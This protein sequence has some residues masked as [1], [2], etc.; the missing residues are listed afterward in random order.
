MSSGRGPMSGRVVL[1]T[2][3]NSG[4]G[5]VSSRV[6]AE[7]GAHVVMVCRD[8]GRGQEALTEVQRAGSAELMR[9][10]LSSLADVRR[11]ALAFLAR[12]PALHVLLNNAGAYQAER[13][14]T[15]DGLELSFGA[16]HL[17]PY[18]L[19]RLLLDRLRE[20]GGARIVN[21]AS[22]AHRLGRVVLDD[23]QWQRRRYVGFLA[24]AD[25]KLMNILFTRE[26]A[27][28]LRGS[29]VTANSLHPGAIRSGFAVQDTGAFARLTALVG[30]ALLSA[31]EGAAT[32]LHLCCA[33]ELAQVSGEYFSSRRVKAP[34]PQ[35]RDDKAALGLWEASERLAGL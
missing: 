9:C 23:L 13:R 21:V 8:L 24:Y 17:G 20:S 7:R 28:R 12:H 33:P 4:I 32:Q 2:G 22:G 6:L 31:E 27:A 3:A 15:A 14:E 26:L 18:L 35:A 34:W 5:R 30:P 16:N 29:G 25:S 10:D 19:T 11:F 1:V